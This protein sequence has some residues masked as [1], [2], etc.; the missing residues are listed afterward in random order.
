LTATAGLRHAVTGEV[1]RSR[2]TVRVP[3]ALR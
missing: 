2:V 1:L 3:S